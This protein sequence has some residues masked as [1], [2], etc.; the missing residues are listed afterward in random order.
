MQNRGMKGSTQ[1]RIGNSIIPA[2]GFR[3]T[4]LHYLILLFLPSHPW[5]EGKVLINLE[6]R[7]TC[8]SWGERKC[9]PHVNKDFGGQQFR[10]S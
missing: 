9:K 10:E 7:N 5:Y 1:A 2:G 6:W 4:L 8:G 3:I